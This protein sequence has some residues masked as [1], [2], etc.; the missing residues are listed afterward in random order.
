MTEKDIGGPIAHD[1]Q[2]GFVLRNDSHLEYRKERNEES[3][4][5]CTGVKVGESFQRHQIFTGS[6]EWA[7]KEAEEF[8]KMRH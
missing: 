2:N 8:I 6:L 4:S 7:I 1:F 5:L 3:Y